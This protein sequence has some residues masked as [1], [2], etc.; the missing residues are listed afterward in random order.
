MQVGR[1][2]RAR[3]NTSAT[4]ADAEPEEL[5]RTT[6]RQ[7]LCVYQFP[8][9]ISFA[10]TSP[11]STPPLRTG[12]RRSM[13]TRG[14]SGREQP[15]T[16]GAAPRED[17]EVP[18]SSHHRHLYTQPSQTRGVPLGQRS[19]YTASTSDLRHSSGQF[20]HSLSST[21]SICKLT[22]E[23]KQ[24]SHSLIIRKDLAGAV[25][26]GGGDYHTFSSKSPQNRRTARDRSSRAPP[27]SW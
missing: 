9:W 18:R 16:Q 2:A 21:K 26:G 7:V 11:S 13:E 23:I 20:K 19:L 22:K 24:A 8:L 27:S 10:T 15:H 6:D 3:V 4:I 14:A 12:P 25:G 5:L 17:D 1:V